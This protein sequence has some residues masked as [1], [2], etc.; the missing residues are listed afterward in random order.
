M[1]LPPLRARVRDIPALASHFAERV[2]QAEGLP[3]KT[4][5]YEALE[6]LMTYSWPG[7]IRQLENAIEMA[8]VL[9]DE[10]PVLGA[11]DFRLPFESPAEFAESGL[12]EHGLDYEQTVNAFET[13][14]LRE[15]LTRTAGNK[16]MAAQLLGLKR[17]TLSAKVRSLENLT[18]CTLM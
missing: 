9:S 17:T 10:R 4:L 7:N 16:K 11:A 14:I 18:G 1:P 2:C 5:D 15:A 3:V 6:M 8:V 13:K 12:P